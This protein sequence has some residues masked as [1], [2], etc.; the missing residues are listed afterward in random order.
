[1]KTAS[2]ANWKDKKEKLLK[3]YKVLTDKDL[4]FDEGKEDE[5][6]EVLVSKLGKTKQELLKIIVML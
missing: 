2:V 3:K 5:M 6:I 4:R 1:M